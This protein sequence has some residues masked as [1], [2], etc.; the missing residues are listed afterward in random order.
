MAVVVDLV[1]IK[2]GL[3]VNLETSFQSGEMAL[4]VDTKRLYVGNI[5]GVNIPQPSMADLSAQDVKIQGAI[6]T[7]N[8][9]AIHI[10]L[11]LQTANISTDTANSAL[12]EVIDVQD[13]I[14]NIVASA[15]NGDNTEQVD[16]RLDANG[17]VWDSTGLHVRDIDNSVDILKN[18]QIYTCVV[19]G[20]S[21]I[22]IN[23]SIT[24]IVDITKINTD[25]YYLGFLLDSTNYTIDVSNKAILLTGWTLALG[26]IL[27]YRVYK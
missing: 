11:A 25:V 27:T 10:A 4:A 23:A 21:S 7:S 16:E 1:Q 8:T 22:P 9:A 17:K 26:E 14:A 19:D 5:D 20:T 15:G 2:T 24:T 18:L 3:S 13:Q 12:N 6:D